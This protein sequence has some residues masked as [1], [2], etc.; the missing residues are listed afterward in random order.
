[1]TRLTE[2]ELEGLESGIQLYDYELTKRTGFSLV[3]IACA[4]AGISESKFSQAAGASKVYVVPITY[5]KGIIPG[6]SQSVRGIAQYMG[7]Q[8]E[9][10][11]EC[12]VSGL[13]EAVGSGA[14]IVFMADDQKFIAVNLTTCAVVDNSYAT[15]RGYVT[16]LDALGKGLKGCDVLVIG[17]GRVGGGAIAALK[18]IGAL[19]T[20]FDLNLRRLHL[21][22]N[23]GVKIEKNLFKVLPQFK[24]I[25]DASPEPGFIDIEHLHPHA[26]IAAP[27]IPLG[28][29]GNA[30]EAFKERVI[31]DPLQ[32]GV[33]AMLAMAAG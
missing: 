21:W 17:A 30:Y 15:A 27:G 14:R 31:H 24:Y 26:A 33:A 23:T 7:F 18:E 3:R 1:M 22:K 25:I 6:F 8:A 32:L 16:A 20:V 10:T 29:T 9:V 19:V 28:L 5:G 4:A 11:F 13:A 12:D 2:C